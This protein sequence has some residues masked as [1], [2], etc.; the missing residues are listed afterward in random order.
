L[1]NLKLRK[2]G[3]SILMKAAGVSRATAAR[4]LKESG[5][6]LPIALLMLLKKTTK[7]EAVRLL[8]GGQSISEVLRAARAERPPGA[9][10]A[11]TSLPDWAGAAP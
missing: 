6:S 4:A 11:G 2:R 10:R 1:T 7:L 8:R 3:E 5:G 9:G